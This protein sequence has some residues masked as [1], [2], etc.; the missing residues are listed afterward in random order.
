MEEN[1][2]KERIRN[3]A[4]EQFFNHGFSKTTMEEFSN[5]LGMS[6]KTIYKYFASKDELVKDIT[7]ATI[8]NMSA[9]CVDIVNTKDI[10]FIEKLKRTNSLLASRMQT[11]R[12]AF[13]IDVQRTMPELWKQID[14]FR[15]KNIFLHFGNLIHEGIEKGVFR[16]DINPQ[17]LILMYAN[18]TQSIINPE[19]LA[20]LP[21]SAHQAFHTII[22][23]LFDGIFTESARD[24]YKNT[25]VQPE[26]M[27]TLP[28]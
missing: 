23:V 13:Y 15:R 26:T 4:K 11:L 1:E 9:C 2:I 28:V 16:N 24:T 3:A 6:K 27:E 12:P 5:G 21:L 25:T 18:A 20:N 17:L 8:E 14:E 10:D 7:I 22:S 19:T